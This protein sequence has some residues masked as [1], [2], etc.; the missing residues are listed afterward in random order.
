MR[1]SVVRRFLLL[2]FALLVAQAI[3]LVR[4]STACFPGFRPKPG[5]TNPQDNARDCEPIPKAPPAAPAPPAPPSAGPKGPAVTT[6]APDPTPPRTP[7]AP[8]VTTPPPPLTAPPPGPAIVDPGPASGD[9]AREIGDRLRDM[10]GDRPVGAVVVPTDP[11]L[12]V[13]SALESLG[14]ALRSLGEGKPDPGR[15]LAAVPR[16]SGDT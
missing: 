9:R 2:I 8:A 14:S 6:P 1:P 4:E 3:L 11:G 12:S 16:A 5:V 10:L 15:L 7:Q 13:D